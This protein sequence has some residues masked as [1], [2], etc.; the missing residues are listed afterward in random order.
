[1]SQEQDKHYMP[2]DSNVNSDPRAE[3][4]KL[5]N[6]TA[7]QEAKLLEQVAALD[8]ED[9]EAQRVADE[10]RI[11]QLVA[12]AREHAAYLIS[13]AE[14]IDAACDALRLLLIE[15]AQSGDE[16][17][18]KFRPIAQIGNQ[19]SHRRLVTSAMNN[20]GL[21]KFADLRPQG[22]RSM[23]DLDRTVLGRFIG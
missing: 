2:K 9:A 16:F 18:R 11:E 5:R 6:F 13:T 20:A 12:E 4:Q 8:A 21:D 19:F 7:E 15:R 14:K 1:M 17:A 10:K 3:L 23:T 22:H